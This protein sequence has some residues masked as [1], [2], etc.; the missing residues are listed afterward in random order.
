MSDND[1]K[2]LI[3]KKI[4]FV[5]P[6]PTIRN[7]VISA[8]RD[9]ELEVYI[10]DRHALLKSVL[11]KNPGSIVFIHL[12]SGLSLNGWLIY[13]QDI[14]NDPDFGDLTVGIISDKITEKEKIWLTGNAKI[15]GGFHKSSIS[16]TKLTENILDIVMN[17]KAKGRRQFVRANCYEDQG[18]VLIWNQDNILMQLKLVDI[19]TSST[20]VQLPVKHKELVKE[21]LSVKGATLKLGQKQ[22]IVDFMVYGIHERAN[23]ILMVAIFK[24]DTIRVLKNDFQTF[25]YSILQKQLMQSI[26]LL[27]PDEKEYSKIGKT[28]KLAPAP[29]QGAKKKSDNEKKS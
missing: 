28:L 13:L 9:E 27:A 7:Y 22:Y 29:D 24:K 4:F 6:T 19:S 25:I 21:N 14:T 18:N 2:D 11:I 17:L 8:L 1:L 16:P 20:A 26:E 3:G 15:G 23:K 12:D 5:N 10:L